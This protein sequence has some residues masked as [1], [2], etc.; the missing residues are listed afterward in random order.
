MRLHLQVHRGLVLHAEEGVEV[1]WIVAG[2]GLFCAMAMS[3]VEV[4]L[5][6]CQPPYNLNQPELENSAGHP[7]PLQL[8]S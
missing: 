5:T 2:R 4:T 3:D 8:T 7:Q 6:Y 1:I